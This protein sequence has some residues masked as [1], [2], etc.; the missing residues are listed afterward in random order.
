MRFWKNG[1]ATEIET[2]E[3]I[4]GLFDK[5][6]KSLE[7]EIGVPICVPDCG[8]CCEVNTVYVRPAEVHLVAI[9]LQ[10]RP[11]LRDLITKK[12]EAWLLSKDEGLTVYRG[13]GTGAM[14]AE[15]LDQVRIEGAY[16]QR[17]TPC[18]FLDENKKCL[19]HD[20]RP[21]VCRAFGVTRV[22]SQDCP[23]PLGKYEKNDYR[24]WIHDETVD[25]IKVLVDRLRD[26]LGDDETIFLGTGLY[27]E[28]NPHRFLSLVYHNTIPSAKLLRFGGASLLWEEQLKDAFQGQTDI[29]MVVNPMG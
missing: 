2:L 13:M 28:L 22:T 23:R 6:A 4:H 9:W 10:R 27:Y 24:A 12:L 7:R 17:L 11:Q 15:Q 16:V 8:K 19:I 26:K 5:A 21:L 3:E 18:P 29:G 25:R 1:S 14:N 20:V